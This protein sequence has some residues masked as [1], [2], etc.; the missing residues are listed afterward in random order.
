FKDASR[1]ASALAVISDYVR[2]SVVQTGAIDPARVFTVHIRLPHRLPDLDCIRAG[3]TLRRLGLR[4]H[5]YF[6]YPANFWRHKNHEMLLTGFL[7]ARVAGLPLH[8]KVFFTGEL[9]KPMN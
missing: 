6:F 9:S 3:E 2:S 8:I 5:E 7:M 1:C 4:P